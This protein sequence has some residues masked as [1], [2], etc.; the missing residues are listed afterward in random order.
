MS[1]VSPTGSKFSYHVAASFSAKN[2]RFDPSTNLFQFNPYNRIQP[3]PPPHKKARHQRPDS[4]HDAF[5]VSRV[6]DS[7][8]VAF[9]VTDGVGGWVESGVDPGD[10]SHAFCDYMAAEAFRYGVDVERKREGRDPLTARRLMDMGYMDVLNDKSIRAGGSTACVGVAAPDGTL[11]VANLG[12]SGYIILRLSAV[13]AYSEPQTHAFNTPF[14]LSVIPPIMATRMAAFGGRGFSDL[15][16]DSDVTHRTLQHG[17]VV[18]FASDGV[19]DNL[20]NQDILHIVSG[21]MTKARAWRMTENGG[22]QTSRDLVLLTKPPKAE[23]EGDGAETAKEQTPGSTLQSALATAITARAKAASMDQKF[24]SPFSKAVQQAYP[25]EKWAGG[26]KDDIC[27]VV[28]LV[29]E[30]QLPKA[31]L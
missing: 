16:R 31:K 29:T 25:G 2:H 26:K 21:V 6:G 9:G 4:G 11:D 15:P 27:V 3:P 12:D 24:D 14:Q 19:W 23:Q 17:D 8:A 18:V 30:E 13:H 1:T 20:F 28:A 22:I 7:G 10:F 5:F